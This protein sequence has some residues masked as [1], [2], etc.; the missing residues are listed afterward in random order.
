[1][2]CYICGVSE[3]KTRLFEAI[4]KTEL[5]KICEP[6]SKKENM[7][8]VRRPTTFQLKEAEKRQNQSIYQRM[9]EE[10]R[11]NPLNSQTSSI[12]KSQKEE[13]SLRDIVDRSYGKKISGEKKPRPDLIQNFHW[14]IMRA[15]R[16][17]KMTRE[18]LAREI[19]ESITAIKMAEQ[20]ILPED[21]DRLISKIESYL[22]IS[23]KEKKTFENEKFRQF[24]QIK[25]P[26]R[27]LKFDPVSTKDITIDDLKRMKKAKQIEEDFKGPENNN[28]DNEELSDEEIDDIIFRK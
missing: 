9:K 7:P 13:T 2:E 26:T 21:D 12:Q 5:I 10:R 16:S 27:I 19:S 24:N 11:K 4:S 18:Q 1:M 3:Q 8:I 6:C 14:V 28:D 17:K 20:G 22:G 23:L 15:R 25:E